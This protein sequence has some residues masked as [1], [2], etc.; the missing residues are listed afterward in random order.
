MQITFNIDGTE[1]AMLSIKNFK[2]KASGF[3]QQFLGKNSAKDFVTAW[4]VA[5]ILNPDKGYR[6]ATGNKRQGS[7]IL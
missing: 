5:T 2:A 7:Y 6:V 1:K 3:S 4:D